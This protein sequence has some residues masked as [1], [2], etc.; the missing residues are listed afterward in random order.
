MTEQKKLKL[1]KLRLF[2][3]EKIIIN[4][5]KE[6]THHIG[7]MPSTSMAVLDFFPDPF[8]CLSLASYAFLRALFLIPL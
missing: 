3:R 1:I 5:I 8:F 7:F 2:F 4:D 6:S